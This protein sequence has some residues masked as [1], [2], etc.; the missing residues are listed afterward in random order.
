MYRAKDLGRNRFQFFTADV[1]ERIRR[2]MELETSLRLALERSEFELHYQPQVDLASGT[3]QGV[4]AL[5]RWRHP[6]KGLIAPSQFIAFAEETGL[7]VPIG[8][9]VLQHAC[10]Q[11]RAWQEAGLP[12]IPV[13]VNMSAKQCEQPDV[14]RVVSRALDDAGLEARYLEL[15]ITESISMA[16]PDESV[17]LMRRLKDTGVALSIDDFGTGFS[18]LS[19]LRR[20]PVDRLKIDLSFVREITTDPS[21]LAISEAIITMSHSLNLKV[22]AEG[23]ETEGQLQLLGAR[24]CDMIQGY[25]FSPPVTAEAF[26]RLMK[27]DRRLPNYPQAATHPSPAMLM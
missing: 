16:N 22:V 5:L 21:S 15:E 3:I 8:E 20:F 19:Y 24:H 23:V 9:W 1:H 11:N 27:E 26:A 18:N 14:D 25:F 17:P 10:R 13:S 6:E 2:R 12:R 4:E 7:I